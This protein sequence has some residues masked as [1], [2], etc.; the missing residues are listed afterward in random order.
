MDL[1]MRLYLL[2]TNLFLV[3]RAL[4]PNEIASN[5]TM[6]ASDTYHN[7]F[8]ESTRLLTMEE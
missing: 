1:N 5:L 2:S 8:A 3:S 6:C 7:L 4:F